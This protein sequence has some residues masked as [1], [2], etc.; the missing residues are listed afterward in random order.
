V[1]WGIASLLCAV[2]PSLEALM[3]FRVLLG[4]GMAMEL[5]IAQAL[6]CE[7]VPAKVRGKYIAFMEGTWPLG[8]MCAG[9][10]AYTILPVYGWRALFVVEAIPCLF[11]LAIRRL[12][13]E[14]PRWLAGAG[15]LEEAEAVMSEIERR[16]KLE[17]KIDQLPAPQVVSLESALDSVIDKT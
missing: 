13:P 12:V 17:L 6:V 1:I 5:P 2:A 9:L 16:V 3:F 8:F 15:K 7:F 10:L 11:V 14:S 4:I